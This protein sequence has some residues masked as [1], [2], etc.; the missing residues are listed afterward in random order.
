M[1]FTL[2]QLTV[3]LCFPIS[4]MVKQFL[5]FSG[6]PPALIH[7]NVILI[8]TGCSVLNL[9]Y[10]SDISLAEVCFIYTLKLEHGG[11]ISM[12][13]QSPWLQFVM[14]LPDS[15]KT[16][17]KG[18]IL[19]RGPWYETPGSLV[20]TNQCRSQVCSSCGVCM[21][22]HLYAFILY[23]RVFYYYIFF[24]AWKSQRGRLVN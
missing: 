13:A 9:L 5:H 23:V 24:C 19:V 21:L 16:E 8:L 12:L 4:S 7:L 17:A 18:M 6:A 20:L 15:P 14:G 2:E 10:Q 1:Y 3:E 22:V 11:R